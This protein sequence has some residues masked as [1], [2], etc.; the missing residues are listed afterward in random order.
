M[1]RLY[2]KINKKEEILCC[3]VVFVFKRRK[4][5]TKLTE[6]SDMF[7]RALYKEIAYIQNTDYS[8]AFLS[9]KMTPK[10]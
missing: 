6:F 5:S 7:L 4:E 1:D 9:I 8:H 3:V 2:L 10:S